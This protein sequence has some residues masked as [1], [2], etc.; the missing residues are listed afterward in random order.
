VN[1][2]WLEQGFGNHGRWYEQER[3]V[4]EDQSRSGKLWKV[5]VAEGIPFDLEVRFYPPSEGAERLNLVRAVP[6]FR[7]DGTRAGWA[8]TCT[9]LTDR[10]QREAALRMTEKLALTGR[11][12]SVVAHEINNPLEAIT[13]LLFL[14]NGRLKEDQTARSYIELAESELQRISGITKQTLRWSK[15]SVQKPQYGTAGDLFKD[16]LQLFTGKIRNRQVQVEIESGEEICVYGTLGQISQVMANLVSNAVQAVPVGGQIW[17]SAK[18]DGHM[19]EIRVRDNGHGMND[20]ALR[21]LFEPFYSTKGD[22]GNGLGLYISHEIMERH[23][24][25]LIVESQVG[26]GTEVRVRLPARATPLN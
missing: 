18:T 10:R 7:A 13:N 24:G 9:D 21:H 14:V 25:S 20:D 11:M 1:Q 4:T 16:V 12:T 23:G 8:G 5:A 15:E 26:T 17:L 19:V 3:L 22:L 6:Y 2:R